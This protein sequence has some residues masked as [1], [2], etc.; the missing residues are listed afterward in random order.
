MA[1]RPAS[2]TGRSS[3]T[4]LPTGAGS[5]PRSEAHAPAHPANDPALGTSGEPPAFPWLALGAATVVLLAVQFTTPS[6][7]G[8]DGYF[9]V[10][11]A[12]VIRETGL[13]NFPPPF[14]WLPLTILG[15]DRYADHHMLY[16]L[17]LVPFTIGDLRIGGKL[18]AVA[19]AVAFVATFAW[20]LRRERIAPLALAV[21]ALGASSPDLLYRLS[22]TR[23]QAL[24]LVCL[25]LGFHLALRGR[26]VALA[27][28]ACVYAW[29]YDGFA[30]LLIPLGA[31]VLADLVLE[32]RLRV[33]IVAAAVVGF[34]VGLVVNPYHPEYLRFILHHFGDKLVPGETLRVGNEWLPY[35]PLGLIGNGLASMLFVTFGVAAVGGVPRDRRVFAALVVA[36]VFMALMLRS[37]RFVEYFA[38]TATLFAVLAYA[39]TYRRLPETR[40]R[41]IAMALAGVAIGNAIG[42]GSTMMRKARSSPHGR[43]AA[44]AEYVAQTAPRGAMLCTTDWDDFPWLYFYN[45]ESTY[46]VGLDPTYLRDVHRDA[47]WRWVDVTQGKVERPGE[48]LATEFP[49]AYVMSDLLHGE[50]LDRAAKDPNLEEVLRDDQQVL[51]RVKRSG[52]PPVFPRTLTDG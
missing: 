48:V 39:D 31:I 41:L 52:P 12:D 16:H 23:V 27:V 49:C 42:V 8:I 45:V 51:Y 25:L 18:A 28:L 24:S 35:T 33:G 37:K 29:L 7:I 6:L 38:P 44:A 32:R 5:E 20:V 19:G 34:T 21:A 14:P 10:R 36:V 40:R 11:Y 47:Y 22:M 3:S 13:L 43:Y 2:P 17:L 4:P 15:P 9:H 1:R 26:F 30:L 50:F 46:L